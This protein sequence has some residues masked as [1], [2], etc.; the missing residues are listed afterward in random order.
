MTQIGELELLKAQNP[1]F[2]W[3]ERGA[4]RN[5]FEDNGEH[6]GDT[7]HFGFFPREYTLI[8][9]TS[10]EVGAIKRASK[11]KHSIITY[12]PLRLET[13]GVWVKGR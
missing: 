9:R 1:G 3:P 13:Y 10:N 11:D 4:R 6:P 12:H 2:N 5:Y 7:R 8:M